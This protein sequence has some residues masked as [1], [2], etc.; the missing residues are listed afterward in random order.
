MIEHIKACPPVPAIFLWSNIIFDL[1]KY[2]PKMAANGSPNVTFIKLYTNIDLLNRIL[3]NKD[4]NKKYQEFTIPV[5]SFYL[6]T[7]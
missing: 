4:P 1:L 6:I 5:C 2:K 7:F 3:F